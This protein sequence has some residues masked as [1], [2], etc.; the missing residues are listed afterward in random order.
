MCTRVRFARLTSSQRCIWLW[1]IY[2][3][4]SR[5]EDLAIHNRLRVTTA[6]L[7]Y[8]GSK[9]RSRGAHLCKKPGVETT[10]HK[11]NESEDRKNDGKNRDILDRAI[12]LNM[13]LGLSSLVLPRI[14]RLRYLV[15]EFFDHSELHASSRIDRLFG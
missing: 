8:Q 14:P 7:G 3:C 2:N 4:D 6:H 11:D 5:S 13:I 9:D 12:R 15:L 10:Q 1:R